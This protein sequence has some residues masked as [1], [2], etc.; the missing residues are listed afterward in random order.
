M[1]RRT[2]RV[3][4]RPYSAAAAI[5]AIRLLVVFC[6]K[7]VSWICSVVTYPEGSTNGHGLTRRTHP[8][9]VGCVPDTE[10]VEVIPG[11]VGL[12]SFT[13]TVPM[14]IPETGHEVRIRVV[15][16]DAE[17]RYVCDE[18]RVRRAPETQP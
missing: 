11:V 15:F 1:Y 3:D 9:N 5:V 12:R 10:E 7:T 6:R 18:V 13:P 4:T 16:D 14:L 17:R 2:V 8:A